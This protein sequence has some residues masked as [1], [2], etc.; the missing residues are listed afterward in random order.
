RLDFY[1]TAVIMTQWAR[2]GRAQTYP[3]SVHDVAG[4][5]AH[6][7][8][9][10]GFLPPNTLFWR[11]QANQTTLGVYVPARRWQVQTAER[12]YHIPMPPFIFVG[13]GTSYKLF[14]V[15]KRPSNEQARLYHAPCPNVYPQGN[16]CQGNTPFPSCSSQTIQTAWQM[17]MEDSQFNADL[18]ANKCVS[19]PDDVRQLWAKLDGKKRFPLSELVSLQK[20]LSW[21]L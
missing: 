3:V 19:S 2:D 6:M 10:S 18:S 9:K 1:G 5:C 17:F 13:N 15:K 4:A 20:N 7:E 8:M 16:I 11:Q 21:L 14:A 12:S